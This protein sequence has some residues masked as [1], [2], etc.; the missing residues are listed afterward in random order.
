MHKLSLTTLTTKYSTYK[1]QNSSTGQYLK[2]N[3]QCAKP[4]E[5]SNQAGTTNT[6]NPETR[7]AQK[8]HHHHAS[9]LRNI[10]CSLALPTKTYNQVSSPSPVLQDLLELSPEHPPE[11]KYPSHA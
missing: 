8:G 10:Y 3:S 5:I 9:L 2:A 11:S 4:Q 6:E 7:K 1:Q